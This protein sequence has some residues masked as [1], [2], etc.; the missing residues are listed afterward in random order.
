MEDLR[1]AF[2]SLNQHQKRQVHL[3][4]CQHA[5]HIWEAYV[6]ACA[7]IAYRDSVVGLHHQV[8]IQLPR[9]ALR[10]VQVNA[11]SSDVATRYQ[12]PIVAM[13][14][15]DLVLPSD[16]TLAYYAIYN[17]HQKY[18]QGVSIDDWLIVK[19]ALFAEDDPIQWRSLLADALQ[20]AQE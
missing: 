1:I 20:R 17:L 7:P 9:D 2:L 13:H 16:I 14:D 4:L 10:C 5:L 3:W 6:H 15:T 11:P 12:E 18:I 8:D 19:Q